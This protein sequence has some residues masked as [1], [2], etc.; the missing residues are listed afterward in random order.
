M[1]RGWAPADSL[2]RAGEGI[3]LSRLK[4]KIEL[5][6]RCVRIRNR[7]F[8]GHEMKVMKPQDVPLLFPPFHQV[9]QLASWDEAQHD[10][11]PGS[12]MHA[13]D[14]AVGIIIRDLEALQ[15]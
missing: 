7:D 4:I 12:E 9:A 1:G 15:A 2:R 5:K 6:Q 3:P 14:A 8:V 11:V 10:G 13:A